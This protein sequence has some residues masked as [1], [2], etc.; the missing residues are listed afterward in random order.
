MKKQSLGFK[1]LTLRGLSNRRNTE[2][3]NQDNMQG[4]LKCYPLPAKHY[5]SG[6]DLF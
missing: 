6:I 4:K 1:C 5:I 3:H 2:K